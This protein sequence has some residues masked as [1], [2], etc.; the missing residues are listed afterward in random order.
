M[1]RSR[2]WIRTAI[3]AALLFSL[4]W[5]LYLEHI[6]PRYNGRRTSEWLQALRSDD[7]DVKAAELAI[8]VLG[9]KAVPQVSRCFFAHEPQ[10]KTEAFDW[11]A[12]KTNWEIKREDSGDLRSMG[13]KAVEILGKQAAPMIP[14]LIEGLG[15]DEFDSACFSGL[16]SIGTPAISPLKSVLKHQNKKIRIQVV[17][18]LVRQKQEDII[19]WL[20]EFLVSGEPELR[21]LSIQSLIALGL[22]KDEALPLLSLL[23]NEK[24]DRLRRAALNAFGSLTEKHPELLPEFLAYAKGPDLVDRL[25][26]IR[27]LHCFN[28]DNKLVTDTLISGLKD[29]DEIVQGAVIGELCL[30]VTGF[31]P[32]PFYYFISMVRNYRW[33]DDFKPSGGMRFSGRPIYARTDDFSPLLK[34]I[35]SKP[36]SLKTNSN[37]FQPQGDTSFTAKILILFFD[38]RLRTLIEETLDLMDLVN[39][40]AQASHGSHQDLLAAQSQI[41]ANLHKLHGIDPSMTIDFLREVVRAIKWSDLAK[42][43]R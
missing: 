36:T 6:D 21:A 24:E 4:S 38:P 5:W 18:I 16:E 41:E 27:R 10:W 31:N 26:V 8:F 7:D 39:N 14:R 42:L 17:R 22:P 12:D 28:P 32:T 30:Q 43:P 33:A 3:L 2:Q 25:V 11:I 9:E 23:L 35:A 20:K 37:G 19:P 1:K 40:P 34:A 15:D 29:S 13:E